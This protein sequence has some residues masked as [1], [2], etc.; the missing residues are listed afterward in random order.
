[1]P[2]SS[3]IFQEYKILDNTL[4]AHK[5]SAFIFQPCCLSVRLIRGGDN[6]PTRSNNSVLTIVD[7][8]CRPQKVLATVGPLDEISVD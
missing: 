7:K 8:I 3:I 4:C 5:N 2:T 1:M 6:I